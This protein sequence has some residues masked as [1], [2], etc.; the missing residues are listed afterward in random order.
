MKIP[1]IVNAQMDARRAAA[2][3]RLAFVNQELDRVK[4]VTNRSS[5]LRRE[6]GQLE[7]QINAWAYLLF[8]GV[9]KNSP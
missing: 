9:E 4:S 2:R 8:E 1:E 7:D 6:R 3:V 5:S